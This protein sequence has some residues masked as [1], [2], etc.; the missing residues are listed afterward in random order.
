MGKDVGTKGLGIVTGWGDGQEGV[1]QVGGD[2]DGPHTH[3]HTLY[4]TLT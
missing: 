4:S 2:R 1:E 3:T